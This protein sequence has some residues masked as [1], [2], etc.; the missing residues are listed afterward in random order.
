LSLRAAIHFAFDVSNDAGSDD[1]QNRAFIVTLSTR[2]AVD[3]KYQVS[4]KMFRLKE[5]CRG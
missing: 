5:L 2:L 1:A 4:A 3:L